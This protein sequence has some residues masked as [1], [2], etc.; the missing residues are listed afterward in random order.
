MSDFKH[1][2][3]ALGNLDEE[4]VLRILKDFVASNPS[5]EE[6][7][8][9]VEACQDGMNIVGEKFETGEYFVGDLIFAGE[10]LNQAI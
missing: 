1:L 9:A 5:Q 10:L 4:E 2:T 8:K 6:A 3:E 7:Q